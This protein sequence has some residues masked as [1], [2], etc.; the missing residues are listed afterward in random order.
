MYLSEFVK[1]L[2]FLHFQPLDI[3]MGLDFDSEIANTVLPPEY[4][5][6]AEQ[7]RPLGNLK[8][9]STFPIAALIGVIL[10]HLPP[11]QIYLNIGVWH[12][13]TLFAGMLLAPEVPC[14]GVDNFSEFGGPRE[15]FYQNWQRFYSGPHQQFYELDY[16][17]YF[18]TQLQ[19]QGQTQTAPIGLYFYDGAHDYAN[20]YQSL[21]LADPFLAPG[22][23]ILVDDT[24]F[25]E[26]RQATLD[27]LR[28]TPGYRLLGDL[29]TAMMHHPTFWNGLMILQKQP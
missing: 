18:Q 12:G 24:N 6:L 26:P 5:H 25:E 21:V 16:Q 3:I 7:A 8:R 17:V 28:A 29:P 19:T 14:V 4:A 1:S 15:V 9:M 2:Q 13:F 11:G 27:F 22:A 23:L 10:K 20:Q